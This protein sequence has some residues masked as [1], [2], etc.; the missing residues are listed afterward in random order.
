MHRLAREARLAAS[1]NHPFIC[2]VHELIQLEDG[3]VF[4]VMEYV[5]GKTLKPS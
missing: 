3:Q 4:F 2:K 1:L 5:E